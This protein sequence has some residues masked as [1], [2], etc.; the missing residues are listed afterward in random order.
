MLHGT[1]QNTAVVPV[2]TGIHVRKPWKLLKT[3][4]RMHAQ[5]D[6]RLHGNDRL[7]RVLRNFRN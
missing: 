4:L 3:S 6:S 5:M 7:H 2:K 1:P